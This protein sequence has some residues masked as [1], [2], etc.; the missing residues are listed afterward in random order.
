LI[1]VDASVVLELL[2]QTGAAA[3]VEARLFGQAA[4]LHAPHLIDAEIAQVLRRY[5]AA[6]D[7]DSARGLQSIAILG[8]LPLERYA[9]G[10]LLQRAWQLRQNISAYDAI[11]VA[12]AELLDATLLTCDRRLAAAPV[13]RAR[14][15]LI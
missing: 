1:V 7:I 9:H 6:G 14:I 5:E 11:Y 4:T 10:L 8:A 3:R 2:L 13:H 15:A 12:L